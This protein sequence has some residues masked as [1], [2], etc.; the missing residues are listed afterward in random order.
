MSA[1]ALDIIPD[2]LKKGF[3]LFLGLFKIVFYIT[4]FLVIVLLILGNIGGNNDNLRIT[5]EN[6]MSDATGYSAQIGTLNNFKFFP[7]IVLDFDDLTF[8]D[9]AKENAQVASVSSVDVRMNFIS[10]ILGHGR[11]KGLAVEGVSVAKDVVSTKPI[12]IEYARIVDTDETSETAQ[13]AVLGKIGSDVLKASVG[14]S[15]EGT[16]DSRSYG[17]A[18]TQRPISASLGDIA[19][20]AVMN[21]GG[22][23]DISLRDILVQQGDQVLASGLLDIAGVYGG[24]E[25][26]GDVKFG[27]SSQVKPQ[28]KIA[29]GGAVSGDV[30]FPQVNPS[31]VAA[32]GAIAT[33][34]QQRI[35]LKQKQPAA[36][37]IDLSAL[38][39][40]LTVDM[41]KI[42]LSG[43]TS[44]GAQKIAVSVK[45]GA[46]NVVAKKGSFADGVTNLNLELKPLSPAKEGDLTPHDLTI[47]FDV[48][49]LSVAQLMRANG[50]STNMIV[51]LDGD[52]VLGAKITDWKQLPGKLKGQV[53]FVTQN[54]HFQ[55]RWLNAWGDGLTS[56]ILPSIKPSEEARLNCAIVDNRIENGVAKFQTLYMDGQHVRIVGEGNYDMVADQLKMRIKPDAKGLQIGNLSAAVKIRGPLSK[57]SIKPDAVDVGKKAAGMLLGSINPAFLALGQTNLAEVAGITEGEASLD[58]CPALTELP[59]GNKATSYA[60]KATQAQ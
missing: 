35:A 45:D 50:Q 41:Q 51:N 7:T 53:V 29:S 16:G 4:V 57:P 23:T 56:L 40:D 54:G 20:S 30:V 55:S 5:I 25:V 22:V 15:A 42:I 11:I 48:D 34:V 37:G 44:V 32:L 9:P 31:E 49:D 58:L 21:G 1:S 12:T 43:D 6:Y 3:G 28:V 13:I 46:A 10:T 17:V 36:R 8:E 39:V 27:Q 19:F 59:A 60:K 26:S 14:V 2:F 18:D 24:Y 38:N 47:D 33:Q 52:A